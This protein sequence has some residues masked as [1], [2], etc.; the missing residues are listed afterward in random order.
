MKE[1]PT[2]NSEET[3]PKPTRKKSTKKVVDVKADKAE[4]SEKSS[5]SEAPV[6]AK[7]NDGGDYDGGDDQGSRE[8]RGHRSNQ[9]RGKS[10]GGKGSG[11]GGKRHNHRQGSNRGNY[12]RDNSGI[13]DDIE[14]VPVS[15]GDDVD[16]SDINL[17]DEEK[18]TLSSKELKS[19]KIE[20]VVA[21]ATKLKIENAAG[22]RRQELVFETLKRAAQLVD[23]FGDGVL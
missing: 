3:K 9:R 23:V 13:Y 2:E 17:S 4:A 8:S 21:L 1:S 11:R 7:S 10:Q 22:L 16:L 19:R 15:G 5:D 6:E 18:A 14:H 20:D 12:Q